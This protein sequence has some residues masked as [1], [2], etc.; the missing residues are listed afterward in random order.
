MNELYFAPT[1]AD[2]EELDSSQSQP[3]AKCTLDNQPPSQRQQSLSHN[4]S[5]PSRKRFGSWQD[6]HKP[7]LI[8]EGATGK[9]YRVFHS[10]TK[11]RRASE[12]ADGEQQV[13][14][15]KK[16]Y[17]IYAVKELNTFNVSAQF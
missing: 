7:K 4:K 14:T 9:V 10:H 6:F 5:V 16:S 11:E 12:N 13:S 1:P 8:G 15:Q 17:T 2:A 3:P